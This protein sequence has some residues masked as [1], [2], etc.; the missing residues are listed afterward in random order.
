MRHLGTNIGVS[1]NTES[2]YTTAAKLV[3]MTF[4]PSLDPLSSFSPVLVVICVAVVSVYTGQGR[5]KV[6]SWWGRN[7]NTQIFTALTLN[8]PLYINQEK[9]RSHCAMRIC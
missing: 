2:H 4:S 5:D 1:G 8:S 7:N 6:T 3:L 9:R